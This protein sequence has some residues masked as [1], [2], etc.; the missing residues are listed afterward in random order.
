MVLGEPPI[1]A[2]VNVDGELRFN[3]LGN[4]I[5][6]IWNR[7][8]RPT[9]IIGISQSCGCFDLVQNPVSK[10]IPA[11]QKLVLPLVIKPNRVD[12]LHQ[13][14]ELFLDHPKQFRVNVDVFGSVK[15]E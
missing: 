5:V 1:R 14:V 15:G 11:N 12:W 9:K 2:F 10:I 8:S 13:R 7:S 3:Q 6:E 4:G